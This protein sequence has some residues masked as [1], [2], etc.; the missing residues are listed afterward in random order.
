MT[1]AFSLILN[2]SRLVELKGIWW[3]FR[4][5]IL[6]SRYKLKKMKNI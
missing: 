2:L 1:N 5:K 6:N 4:H 3:I